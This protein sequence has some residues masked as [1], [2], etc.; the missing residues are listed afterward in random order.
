MNPFVKTGTKIIVLS[1]GIFATTGTKN[2]D[3]TIA[4]RICAEISRKIASDPEKVLQF[5][6]WT[7][8]VGMI[9]DQVSSS[10]VAIEKTISE[11]SELADLCISPMF[12]KRS[13]ADLT[14]GIESLIANML[15]LQ[16]PEFQSLNCFS[17]SSTEKGD[18]QIS[19]VNLTIN[20]HEISGK[21][22]VS[23][24]RTETSINYTNQ[25]IMKG[26]DDIF[27]NFDVLTDEPFYVCVYPT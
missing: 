3:K 25:K 2:K 26:I 11:K 7:E 24:S 21:Y 13:T 1:S 6:G 16:L 17:I 20:K 8:V 10:I 14:T 19:L 4:E 5:D 15:E 23:G 22:S 12:V 27:G 9:P 18:L